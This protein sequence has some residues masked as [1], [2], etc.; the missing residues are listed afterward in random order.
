MLCFFLVAVAHKNGLEASFLPKMF[1]DSAGSGCHIHMSIE[2]VL[3][4]D[5]P[6]LANTRCLLPVGW[7]GCVARTH[8]EGVDSG[9]PALH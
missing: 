5:T 1:P 9:G 6:C 8:T 7:S 4:S 2:K 3:A